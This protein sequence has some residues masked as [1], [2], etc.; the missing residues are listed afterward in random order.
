[1]SLS[2][3]HHQSNKNN[4]YFPFNFKITHTWTSLFLCRIVSSLSLMSC[5]TVLF[6][7][8][9]Q[10]RHEYLMTV[11][12]AGTDSQP[13][14][15]AWTASPSSTISASAAWACVWE[16]RGCTWVSVSELHMCRCFS[17]RQEEWE[18]GSME[19]DRWGMWGWNTLEVFSL[20]PLSVSLGH[21][22]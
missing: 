9:D 15:T 22:G 10:Q 17:E 4:I 20:I 6:S 14:G 11:A 12:T 5:S 1:M 7:L 21:A 19:G 13:P 8:K 2:D 3:Q 18:E 16:K